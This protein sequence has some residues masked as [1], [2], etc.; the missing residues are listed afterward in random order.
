MIPFDKF[1]I[2]CIVW[3]L[4]GSEHHAAQLDGSWR[5]LVKT[6]NNMRLMAKADIVTNAEECAEE[7]NT[8]AADF[9]QW[10]SNTFHPVCM[11]LKKESRTQKKSVYFWQ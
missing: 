8:V 1:G 10:V 3:N 6:L 4:Q 11:H 9:Q 2:K 7:L 5:T